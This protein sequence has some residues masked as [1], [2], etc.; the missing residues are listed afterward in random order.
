MT[1][2]RTAL[3][4][5]ATGGIGGALARRLQAA[6]WTVRALHRDPAQAVRDGRAMP[7][8]TWLRG[9]AMRPEDVIEAAAGASL[10]VHAVNPPRYRHW[11]RLVL[12]MLE[13]SVAAARRSGARIFLPGTVYNFGPDALPA[14]HEDSPQNPAS[15]KGRI[16][17][18]MERRLQRAAGGEGVRSLVLRAG[19]YFGPGAGSSWFSQAMVRPGR[20]LRAVY[21]PGRPGIGHQWA[22]LPDVAETA[23]RL[24]QREAALPPFARFHMAGHWDPDGGAVVEAVRRAAGEP[25][26]PCRRFPWRILAMAAPAVPMFREMLE[27]RY[28]WRQPVRLDNARLAALLGEEPH[29]PLH[30]AVHATLVALDCLPA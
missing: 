18:E 19:D 26:L 20:R 15:R 16:R 17:A 28:L 3:V 8:A 5:G 14:P 9:D 27:M 24:L 21:Q 12:P 7:G 11:D 22:Y 13:S 30:R 4:L 23:F 10:I 2:G 1:D 29:T 25:G 6:G